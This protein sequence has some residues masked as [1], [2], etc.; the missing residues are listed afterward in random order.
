VP[1]ARAPEVRKRY[2]DRA[3]EWVAEWVTEATAIRA[4]NG[5]RPIDVEEILHVVGYQEEIA[6]SD[7]VGEEGLLAN[8]YEPVAEWIAGFVPTAAPDLFEP[9]GEGAQVSEPATAKEVVLADLRFST[10][11][12]EAQGQ[13]E[14]LESFVRTDVV[15]KALDPKHPLILGRKGTGKTAVFR[16]LSED[17]S[18]TTVVVLSPPRLP[19]RRR[20]MPDAEAFGAIDSTRQSFG[21]EWRVVWTLQI[22]L[23]C[24]IQLREAGVQVPVWPGETLQSQTQESSRLSASQFVG[25]LRKMLATPDVGLVG[26]DWLVALD[27]AAPPGTLLLF[28]GLDT[29]FGNSSQELARRADAIAGLLSLLNVRGDE[30]VNL[31]F[32]TLLREDIWRSVKV[33]NKSHFFGQEVRLAWAS[34]VDYLKVAIKQALRSNAFRQL[35]IQELST[36]KIWPRAEPFDVELWQERLVYRVWQVLV[37][38]RISGGKTA[39]TYNWVWR[40][41]SDGNGA[42]GPRALLQLF[43]EALEREKEI[44]RYIPYNRSLLRPR[45]LVESLDAVSN[46]AFEALR[47]E[48]TELEPLFENLASIGRTPFAAEDLKDVDPEL[49]SLAE[50]VGLLGLDSGRD[51]VEKY[52]V[53]ELYRKALGMGRRGQA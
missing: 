9:L 14:F 26:W 5:R 45:A 49:E 17:P 53:P 8:P 30:L 11:T 27:E 31:R 48:F 50:E 22:G 1:G 51:D 29:G 19:S 24:F 43:H 16:K 36:E 52:R 10:G 4:Q 15:T 37:G 35:L 42:H 33:P 28:D 18:M 12:A 41:L 38:E 34:Q 44:N 7:V 21:L 25:D 40:R 32:K 47:E 6:A 13:E 3:A 39:F 46:E 23:A 2:E 20:W